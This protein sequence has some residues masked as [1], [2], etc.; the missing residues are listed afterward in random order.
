MFVLANEKIT[1]IS[2][3]VVPYSS[4]VNGARLL[5]FLLLVRT[6]KLLGHR[7]VHTT[8]QL[9]PES[10]TH[11]SWLLT[12]CQV[13]IVLSRFKRYLILTMERLKRVTW[14]VGDTPMPRLSG[15]CTVYTQV[16]SS[17]SDHTIRVWDAHSGL[18]VQRL[19]GHQA[20]VHI[21]ECHPLDH[22]LAMS[23]SYDG[24]T[25]LWNLHTGQLLTR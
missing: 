1:T 6:W 16:L 8:L 21:L 4:H 24:T 19:V 12:A 18:E 25:K 3:N 20:Q 11:V 9:S 23:A 15:L 10:M 5:L 7:S 2:Y 13:H 17:V 14:F 22:K